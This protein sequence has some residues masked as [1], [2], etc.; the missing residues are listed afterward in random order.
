MGCGADT[1]A[2]TLIDSLMVGEDFVIPEIDLSG[3]EFQ[4]PGGINGPM[5]QPVVPLTEA[6]L[7][8]RTVAGSGMFDGLMVSFSNHLKAEYEKGRIT[9]ADYTKTYIALTES[10]LSGAV[11]FLLGKD[12][13]FWNAQTAQVQAI[14]A[15]V[16]LQMAKVQLA[17]VQL[18]A[19]NQKATYAL[20]KLKLSTESVSYCTAQY[21]LEQLLPEQ[22]ANLISQGDLVDAQK[23]GQVA[24][25]AISSFNLSS[26]L[27]EQLAMLGVQKVGQTT[28]NSTL[29][30]TLAQTLPQQLLNLQEQERMLKE[31]KESQRAQTADVRSDGLTVVGVLGK[32]KALYSQ[33]ITSYER[34][35]EVKTAK[36]FSDAWITQKTMDEGLVPPTG[37]TNA[38]LDTILTKL[39]INNGLT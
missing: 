15:Q 39:K 23:A 4:V 10:A 30:Y 37:F 26:M 20:T 34:D 5:Y 38:S 3:P 11:S 31:Q 18:E 14:T 21:T 12:Q 25:T 24:E 32:Q 28:Q 36:I 6:A 35:A 1:E 29:A 13:A 8:T 33:Q 16:Q 17:A 9:G 19:L 22:K 27:P 2:N 7:T